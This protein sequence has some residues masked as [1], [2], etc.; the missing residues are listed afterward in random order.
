MT[1]YRCH[2]EEEHNSIKTSNR[3]ISPQSQVHEISARAQTSALDNFIQADFPP[4]VK[5]LQIMQSSD[6]NP[7]RRKLSDALAIN[8]NLLLITQKA[9]VKLMLCE[10]RYNVFIV[11]ML[12]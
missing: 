3:N 11:K 9:F 8:Y 7:R 5:L 4:C 2:I 6:L 10:R 12:L 1:A